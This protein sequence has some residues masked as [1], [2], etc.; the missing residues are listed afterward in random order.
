MGVV[1]VTCNVDMS[2]AEHRAAFDMAS[3]INVLRSRTR[4]HM[5]DDISCVCCIV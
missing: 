1:T 2:C 4:A 3:V 5:H